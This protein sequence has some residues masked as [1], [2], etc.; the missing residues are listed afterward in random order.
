MGWYAA[1]IAGRM[2]RGEDVIQST[3][4]AEE[5]GDQLLPIYILDPNHLTRV[6]SLCCV[7]IVRVM[8]EVHEKSRVCLF[9][10][11]HKPTKILAE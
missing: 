10:F 2:R 9:F 6:E 8:Q 11:S 7:L 4:M 5:E 1:L 3:V